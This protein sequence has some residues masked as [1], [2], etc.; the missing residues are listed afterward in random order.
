MHILTNVRLIIHPRPIRGFPGTVNLPW[1]LVSFMDS[2]ITYHIGIIVANCWYLHHNGVIWAS[3][4]LNSPEPTL[5][6][7]NPVQTTNKEIVISGRHSRHWC[8]SLRRYYASSRVGRF[9]VRKA[10]S[11]TNALLIESFVPLQWRHNERNGVSNPGMS[12]VYSTVCSG[13]DQR[14][15]QNSVLLAFVRGIHRWPVDPHTKGQ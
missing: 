14:K 10:G 4:L 6:V 15:F 11:W 7:E 8:G 2:F 3:K 5:F 12:I 1:G 13:A 9:I